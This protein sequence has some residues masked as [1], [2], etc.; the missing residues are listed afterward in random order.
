MIYSNIQGDAL[1][2]SLGS[3]EGQLWILESNPSLVWY[4]FDIFRRENVC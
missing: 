4:L 3:I 1:F 2:Y